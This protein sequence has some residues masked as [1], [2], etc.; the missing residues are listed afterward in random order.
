[1]RC[2]RVNNGKRLLLLGGGHAHL[3]LI[4]GASE[5]VKRGVQVTLVSREP[6]QYYSGMGPGMLGGLYEPEQIRFPVAQ[7]IE[8]AGGSFVAGTA[9]RIDSDR[10][11]VYLRDGTT[12]GYDVL[13]CNTG[14]AVA[15]TV[16]VSEAGVPVFPAKP[17][18]ELVAARRFLEQHASARPQLVVI[19]AGP[20]A[21]EI[22]GHALHWT[23]HV[24]IVCRRSL[25]PGFPPCVGRWASA[26]LERRGARIVPGDSVRRVVAGAVVLAD[27]TRI[28]CD[29]VIQA[30]GVVPSA[31][32]ARS[33][34][35]TGPD[36]GLA[37]NESLCALGHPE[38][39]GG[40]DCIWYTP[41]AL[42]K[43]GVFAVREAPVLMDNVAARLAANRLRRFRP[44]GAY[45][46]AV[47]LGDGTAVAFRRVAGIP[48]AAR[49]RWVWRLKDRIDR[50]FMKRYGT[51]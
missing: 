49:G 4:A 11:V 41:Q 29:A 2:K 35:P 14:S 5:L 16:T 9:V 31:L 43:A 28:R 39:L 47:G 21:V 30:T 48:M 6:V 7:M 27:G 20:A 42:A 40:G 44:G 46:L 51:D 13:S 45:L 10:R 34:L 17:I 24:S 22:A 12:H 36:G 26:S 8:R 32:Y 19:G 50:E 3:Y 18:A 33:G 15:G 23:P 1:M 25:L 38:I 37:V